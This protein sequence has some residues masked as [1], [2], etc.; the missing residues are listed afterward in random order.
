MFGDQN[1]GD[2]GGIDSEAINSPATSS[3]YGSQATTSAGVDSKGIDN[4]ATSSGY[5]SQA[6]T[7]FDRAIGGT[8]TSPGLDR[9]LRYP[10]TTVSVAYPISSAFDNKMCSGLVNEPDAT[11]T[12]KADNQEITTK[13]QEKNG[14]I[15]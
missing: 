2:P 9:P 13:V 10:K 14:N 3:G 5:R 8:A 4:P 6:T 15:S 11:T 7:G 12:G 1:I